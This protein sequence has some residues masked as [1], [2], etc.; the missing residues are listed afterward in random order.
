MTPIRLS[1][2]KIDKFRGASRAIEIVFDPKRPITI[3]FGENGSG[4]STIIDALDSIFNERAGSIDGV[5]GAKPA[6]HL[7]SLNSKAKDISLSAVLS[8]SAILDTRF[9][10]AK[11][12]TTSSSGVCSLRATVLRRKRILDLVDSAPAGRYNALAGFID[13]S[14][15]QE[16]EEELVKAIKEVDRDIDSLKA[17]VAAAD[18]MLSKLHAEHSQPGEGTLTPIQ[19]A[20]GFSA[21][22]TAML[23]KELKTFSDAVDHLKIVESHIASARGAR[24]LLGK[25]RSDANAASERLAAVCKSTPDGIKLLLALLRSAQGYIAATEDLADCPLCGNGVNR[26]ALAAHIA[27]ELSR[28]PQVEAAVNAESAA[29]D[30]V[31]KQEAVTKDCLTRLVTEAR[32]LSMM[33]GEPNSPLA[34]AAAPNPDWKKIGSSNEPLSKENIAAAEMIFDSCA[35]AKKPWEAERDLRQNRLALLHSVQLSIKNATEGRKQAAI[36]EKVKAH[37]GKMLNTIRP[38]RIAFVESEL[39]SVQNECDRIYAMI[40]PREPIGKIKL[41]LDQN[42]KGSCDIEADFFGSKGVPP[43]A[44]YSESHLDTLGFCLF[45]ALA[46]RDGGSSN[47]LVLDD[48][49]TSVDDSHSEALMEVLSNEA[50]NF[51]QIVFATHSRKVLDW[52]RSGKLPHSRFAVIELS[53]NWSLG[54]GIRARG[55][56]LERARIE[57]LAS[58]AFL[59]RTELAGCTRR[60]LEGLLAEVV[61]P[62]GATGRM[63]KYGDY[64]LSDYLGGL[65]SVASDGWKVVKSNHAVGALNE[66]HPRDSFDLRLKSREFSESKNVVNKLV[67]A[68]DEGAAYTDKEAKDFA[69]E[70]ILLANYFMCEKCGS[71]IGVNKKHRSCSCGEW[72]LETRPAIKVKI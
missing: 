46:R 30:A 70:V 16:S 24:N 44:Y 17:S 61:I 22:D 12:T 62:L 28:F 19:W 4:K 40:H 52:Y 48:I 13:V 64:E 23:R 7:P 56:V 1:K 63:K 55:V 57:E 18:E 26:S 8:D 5:S 10:G 42:K 29:K 38:L 32:N 20:T 25:L 60:F 9:V 65:I 53:S 43:Q 14:R 45:L 21:M 41:V 34:A 69:A 47:V 36:Y 27:T 39:M 33:I 71:I 72:K 58:A 3:I 11:I 6:H 66:P 37:L 49:F 50:E 68:T 31:K 2:L 15:I 67:H 54:D 51:A 35:P 59:E